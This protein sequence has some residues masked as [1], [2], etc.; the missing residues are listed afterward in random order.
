MNLI[1]VTLLVWSVHPMHV[2]EHDS[3]MF[4]PFVSFDEIDWAVR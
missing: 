4:F 2:H 1:W 3:H